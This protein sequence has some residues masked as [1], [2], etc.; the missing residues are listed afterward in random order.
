[1][2][3]NEEIKRIAE[4][5]KNAIPELYERWPVSFAPVNSDYMA[6]LHAYRNDDEE[7]YYEIFLFGDDGSL[8]TDFNDP[9]EHDEDDQG[10]YYYAG[11]S[12]EIGLVNIHTGKCDLLYYLSKDDVDEDFATVSAKLYEQTFDESGPES[13]KLD[14]ME[15]NNELSNIQQREINGLKEAMVLFGELYDGE[16]TYKLNSG[17]TVTAYDNDEPGDMLVLSVKL[18]EDG[19]LMLSINDKD[20]FGDEHEIDSHDLFP[21]HLQY[22]TQEIQS[23]NK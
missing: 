17:V 16:Y 8:T 4:S 11:L 5:I 18:N 19:R 20:E 13:K 1:M 6:F 10:D 7:I 3:K 12:V 15:I 22:V 23:E 14:V 9:P 2:E 21:G